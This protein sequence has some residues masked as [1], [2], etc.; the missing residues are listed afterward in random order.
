MISLR[1]HIDDFNKPAVAEAAAERLIVVEKPARKAKA[2]ES[3][4]TAAFVRLLG[5]VGECGQRAVPALGPELSRSVAEL[6]RELGENPAPVVVTSTAEKAGEELSRWADQAAKFHA[7]NERDIKEIIDVMVRASETLVERDQRYGTQIGDLTGKLRGLAELDNLGLIRRSILESTVALKNCIEKMAEEGREAQRKLG[8]EVA[9][10]KRRLAETEKLSRTDALT[11]L[12]NRRAFEQ[13]L[14]VRIVTKQAFSLLLLDLNAFK[15]VNDT[16]GHAAGDD[17]LK[18]FAGE[19]QAQFSTADLVARWGG[20]EFAVIASGNRW[21]AESRAEAIRR[22]V[23]GIYKLEIGGQLV[24]LDV[25]AALAIV[26]WDG[27]ESAAEIL[28]RADRGVY[29]GKRAGPRSE[30]RRTGERRAG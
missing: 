21:D 12:A 1:K 5:S 3:P 17:L 24:K 23:L 15:S 4:G 28:E 10:Y 16:Y 25:D 29:A 6:K 30:E 8:G 26:E 7:D 2:E 22:W 18:Q 27:A 9:E 13:E 19:L 11:R 20:D 14:E